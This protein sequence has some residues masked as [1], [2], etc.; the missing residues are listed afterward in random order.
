LKLSGRTGR[1]SPYLARC[2]VRRF[3]YRVY[4]H[5]S[6]CVCNH[7]GNRARRCLRFGPATTWTAKRQPRQECRHEYL[8]ESHDLF[9]SKF[10]PNDWRLPSLQWSAGDKSTDAGSGPTDSR[11]PQVPI[12]HLGS[13]GARPHCSKGRARAALFRPP[14]SGGS[15][16]AF[17]LLSSRL[18]F[19]HPLYNGVGLVKRH[20]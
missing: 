15:P 14:L 12:L 11:V 2:L 7:A 5:P 8:P 20:E 6:R 13:W 4:N 9:L 16:A 10:M 19:Y 17:R 3:Y 1:G 18:P